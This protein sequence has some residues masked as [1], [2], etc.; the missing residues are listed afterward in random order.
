MRSH[1]RL[2]RRQ[3]RR[4]LQI[5]IHPERLNDLGRVRQP[6]VLDHNILQLVTFL[7]NQVV[8]R[9]H[10]LRARGAANAPIRKLISPLLRKIYQ[11][12]PPSSLSSRAPQCPCL[13]RAPTVREF[14]LN[15]RDLE[16][17]L[18]LQQMLDERGLAG[19]KIAAQQDDLAVGVF[20]HRAL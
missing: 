17:L 15:H 18:V 14:V 12:V 7:L 1:N 5:L 2:H 10:Q 4:I 3:L 20:G 11:K 9:H 13:I 8:N 19:A 16:P 6:V